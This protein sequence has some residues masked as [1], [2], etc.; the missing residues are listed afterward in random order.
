MLAPCPTRKYTDFGQKPMHLKHASV[1]NLQYSKERQ[2]KEEHFHNKFYE[3]ILEIAE[4]LAITVD[5]QQI[6][7]CHGLV[8]I[9]RRN[10]GIVIV[11]PTCSGKT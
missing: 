10:K 3:S 5:E 4:E 9:M 2:K 8:E 11:G 6:Y 1:V 7:N